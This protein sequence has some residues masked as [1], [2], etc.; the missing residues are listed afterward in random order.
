MSVQ[1]KKNTNLNHYRNDKN[2]LEFA[3]AASSLKHTLKGDFNWVSV[4]EV[5]NLMNG[6]VSGRVRR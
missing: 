4:Q 5:E 6:D 3:T 2:A 1:S